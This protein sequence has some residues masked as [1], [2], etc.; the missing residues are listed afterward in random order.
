MEEEDET[1]GRSVVAIVAEEVTV[2]GTEIDRCTR[3]LEVEELVVDENRKK[4]V[5]FGIG[6]SYY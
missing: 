3:Y 1:G 6:D 4:L 2:I 5:A